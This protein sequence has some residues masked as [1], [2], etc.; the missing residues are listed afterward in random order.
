MKVKFSDLSVP[1]KI[2]I[3]GSYFIG[4]FYLLLF[5]VGVLSAMWG[6]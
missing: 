2:A 4:T 3:I 6:N 5:L 1:L